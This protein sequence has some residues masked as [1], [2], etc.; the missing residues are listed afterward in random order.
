MFDRRTKASRDALTYLQETHGKDLWELIIPVDT[1]FRD[2][3]K[4][5]IPLPLLQ[6]GARGALAYESLIDTLMDMMGSPIART[7]KEVT[8][9]E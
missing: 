3:S 7:G 1:Q 5:G 2:A 6:P 9:Y 4:A 8:T